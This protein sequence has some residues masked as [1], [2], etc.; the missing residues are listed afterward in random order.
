MAG[1]FPR[2]SGKGVQEV[3]ASWEGMQELKQGLTSGPR[4]RVGKW[5]RR[6]QE[7]E[8]IRNVLCKRILRYSLSCNCTHLLTE[9]LCNS[10]FGDHAQMQ[11]KQHRYETGSEDK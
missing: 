3:T 10:Y 1:T 8:D 4:L 6:F 7:W 11:R 9:L 5:Q 2:V